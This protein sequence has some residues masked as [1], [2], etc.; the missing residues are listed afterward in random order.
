[1]CLIQRLSPD[2]S[3]EAS[4]CAVGL[5][6]KKD[7]EAAEVEPGACSEEHRARSHTETTD[8]AKL[9]PK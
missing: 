5:S 2:F 3:E 1:M 6:S 9:P 7:W 4:T 8:G